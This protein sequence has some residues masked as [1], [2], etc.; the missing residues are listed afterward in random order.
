MA[1]TGANVGGASVQ[2][3]VVREVRVPPW[4]Y[5]RMWWLPP[6]RGQ[7]QEMA[8]GTSQTDDDGKFQVT[9]QAKPDLS[10]SRDSE[11]TFHFTVYADVTDGTG[12]TRSDQISV[13]VG[14]TAL[15]ASLSADAWQTSDKSVELSIK[16]TSLDGVA[17]PAQGSVTIYALVQPDKVVRASLG[18]HQ[19]HPRV[20]LGDET[21]PKDP[22]NPADWPLGPP[23]FES[24]FHTDASGAQKLQ[25]ELASGIYRAVLTTADRFGQKVTAELPLEVVDLGAPHW[26]IKLPN[27]VAFESSSVEPG[28]TLRGI[29]ASG[30]PAASVDRGRA[31]WQDD[32]TLLDHSR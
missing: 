8:R 23:V 5:W 20:P 12:E 17:Q 31:P 11:P 21:P 27:R 25:A 32:P 9:F 18:S 24:E 1:Y 6:T 3:R 13:S 28:Q 29:W 22:S 16:T 30:Y 10:V 2:W 7:S 15:S 19:H 4:W 14:Y 26:N